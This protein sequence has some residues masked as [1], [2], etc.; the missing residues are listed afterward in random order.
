MSDWEHF[1]HEVPWFLRRGESAI[2]GEAQLWTR[3]SVEGLPELSALLAS[4]TL[5]AVSVGGDTYEL[6]AWGS[7]DDRRGWLCRPPHDVGSDSVA[8]THKNFWKLCGGIVER[9]REPDTWWNN[10]NEVL[11]V[12]A[13]HVRVADVLTDYAWLWEDDDLKLSIDPDEYYAVA[14]EANGNLTLA[15]R[16]D[17]RL[18][19]FAPDHAFANVAPLA[20]SPPYSLLTIDHVPNLAAWIEVCASAWR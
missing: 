17:G 4:T 15:H 8:W 16:D 7:S 20:G 12:N 14:A 5:T 18:L 13:T 9:F 19:L 3:G 11:T 6:L 1:V 2:V 10:Q